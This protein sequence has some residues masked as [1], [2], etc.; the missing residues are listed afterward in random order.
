METPVRYLHCDHVTLASR[1]VQY[2]GRLMVSP[3]PVIRPTEGAWQLDL[4]TQ[5]FPPRPVE[6]TEL[7]QRAMRCFLHVMVF[8]R[9]RDGRPVIYMKVADI[10]KNSMGCIS[11]PS[12]SCC[13]SLECKAA[14]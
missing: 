10:V 4:V 3:Y 9:D 6:G 2:R 12:C 5:S 8:R 7:F 1:G 11:L 13:F 14:S